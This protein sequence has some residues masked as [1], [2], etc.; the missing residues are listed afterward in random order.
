MIKTMDFKTFID[1]YPF[2]SVYKVWPEVKER[3][4]DVKKKD[5]IN[6]LNTRLKDYV[7]KDNNKFKRKTYTNYI[8]GWQMD[9]LVSSKNQN[10]NKWHDGMSV[11]GNRYYLLCI[12]INTRFI[13]ASNAI[14]RKDVSTVLP[15]IKT[16]VETFKPLVI[17]CDNEGAFTAKSTVEYLVDKDV[18]LKVITE[19]LHSSLGIINRA[20]RT[21]RDMIGSNDIKSDK[22]HEVINVYNKSTH[23]STGMSPTYMQKHHDVEEL[24]I[25]NCILKDIGVTAETDYD[26]DVGTK[27]R[28]I[29]DKKSFSKVR[30][31]VS[32]GYYTIDNIEGNNYVIIAKDGTTKKIPRYRLLP[33]KDNESDYHAA[34]TIEEYNANRGVIDEILDY[35]VKT[36]KYKVRFTVPDSEPYIDTI[37]ATFMRES[38]PTSLSKLERE[39]F[40][41]NKDKYKV[42]KLKIT[43][44]KWT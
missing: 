26:L 1:S 38:S 31:K 28:Y 42:D 30:H 39:F 44:N 18:E 17:I 9:L 33:L 5:V 7:P 6:Y 20:C 22:L 34:E 37:S 16:F 3:Y 13:Y 41:K 2:K 29:L 32:T 12:N 10:Y 15:E 25:I 43:L 23:H 35:N 36:K 21:L 4:P 19:Q 14:A 11:T 24:Y 40:N 27:V 8:G